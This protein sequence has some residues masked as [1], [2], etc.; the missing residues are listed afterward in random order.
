MGHESAVCLAHY[1]TI[2]E[3]AAAA[4][5]GGSKKAPEPSRDLSSLPVEDFIA[6]VGRIGS[7]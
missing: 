2:V 1:T 7:G 5:G 3:V 6:Q 4:F